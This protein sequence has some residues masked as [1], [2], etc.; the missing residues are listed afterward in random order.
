MAKTPSRFSFVI[1]F[2]AIYGRRLNEE[3]PE[4]GRRSESILRSISAHQFPFLILLDFSTQI[5]GKT[6]CDLIF[7]NMI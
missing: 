6:K 2:E 5:D 4:G 1:Q 3:G 7:F